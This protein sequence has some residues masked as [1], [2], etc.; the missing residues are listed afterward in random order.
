MEKYLVE[1]TRSTAG[2]ESEAVPY[3]ANYPFGPVTEFATA[4]EATAKVAEM[5]AKEY[6]GRTWRAVKV[7][8]EVSTEVLAEQTGTKDEARV[9]SWGAGAS[10]EGEGWSP[11]SEDDS[12]ETDEEPSA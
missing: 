9:Q 6:R 2:Y 5:V 8:T 3:M 12:E 4:E 1:R 11:E 7:S 10:G